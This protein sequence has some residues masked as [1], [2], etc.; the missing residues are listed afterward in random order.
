[1]VFVDAVDM[2]DG[3]HEGQVNFDEEL[4]GQGFHGIVQDG[5]YHE[6]RLIGYEN[7]RIMATAFR[8]AGYLEKIQPGTA[9]DISYKS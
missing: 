3:D 4:P 2:K 6:M 9:A 1:M 5:A 7:A 8:S